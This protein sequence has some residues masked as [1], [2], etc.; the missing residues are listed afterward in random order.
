MSH[1]HFLLD[2]PQNPLTLWLPNSTS[3][4]IFTFHIL[5]TFN[6][7]HIISELFL[8]TPFLKSEAYQ[9]TKANRQSCP[10]ASLAPPPRL[11]QVP[12]LSC[13][14]H[15]FWP[16]TTYQTYWTRTMHWNKVWELFQERKKLPKQLARGSPHQGHEHHPFFF[17]FSTFWFLN[18]A[19][20]PG[21]FFPPEVFPPVLHLT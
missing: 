1:Q 14:L 17:P 16:E 10:Y 18:P 6:H 4:S 20:F 9:H 5:W 2:P 19:F 8:F 7:A 3:L 15:L 11:H 21:F 12:A 13:S